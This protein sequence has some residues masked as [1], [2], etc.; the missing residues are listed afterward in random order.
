M[1]THHATNPENQTLKQEWTTPEIIDL[2]TKQTKFGKGQTSDST[3]T[4]GVGHHS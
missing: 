3:T 1:D 4:S 2:D